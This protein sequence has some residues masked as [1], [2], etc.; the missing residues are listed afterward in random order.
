MSKIHAAVTNA[1]QIKD[2]TNVL[3]V[4]YVKAADSGVGANRARAF[5]NRGFLKKCEQKRP[6]ASMS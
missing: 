5:Q 3:G 4:S 2:L 6:R 1:L